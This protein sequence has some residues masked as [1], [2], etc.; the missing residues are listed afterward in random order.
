VWFSEAPVG[1]TPAMQTVLFETTL[2][3]L[4][5]TILIA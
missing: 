1:Y 5:Y 2:F 4:T 3:P